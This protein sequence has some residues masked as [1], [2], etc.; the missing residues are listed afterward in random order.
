MNFDKE[1]LERVKLVGE[2]KKA[3][4]YTNY[5]NH[6]LD[7][8]NYDKEIIWVQDYQ[9]RCGWMTPAD[10]GKFIGMEVGNIQNAFKSYIETGKLSR[11]LYTRIKDKF[12][13]IK[14]K[15]LNEV[16]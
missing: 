3:N 15:D 9:D 4:Y 14:I 1:L 16:L 7:E 11:T 5:Y 12:K 10:F 13:N 2:V 6:C 8:Y